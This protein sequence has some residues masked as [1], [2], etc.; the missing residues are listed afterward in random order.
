MTR[1]LMLASI[2]AAML[3]VTCGA[4]PAYA[5]GPLFGAC[6]ASSTPATPIVIAATSTG[7]V[8]GGA[9]GTSATVTVSAATSTLIVLAVTMATSGGAP[10]AFAAAGGGLTWNPPVAIGNTVSDN[11]TVFLWAAAT[12]TLA[13]TVLT[14]SWTNSII[15]WVSVDALVISGAKNASPI[16]MTAIANLATSPASTTVTAS[17]AGSLLLMATSDWS[18]A[19]IGTG[20]DAGS[21]ALAIFATPASTGGSGF[22]QRRTALTAAP[23]AVTMTWGLAGADQWQSSAIEILA[24]P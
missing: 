3:V 24:G 9:A 22:L 6:A 17:A 4:Q 12:G 8:N 15:A 10:G 11:A 7:I 1:A 5:D 23:G 21:T 19:V 13:G 2:F 20:P 14:V 16:G 18:S